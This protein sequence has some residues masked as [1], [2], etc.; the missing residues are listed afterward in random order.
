LR[1]QGDNND[2][3]DIDN[4]SGNNADHNANIDNTSGIGNSDADTAANTD[5]NDR[6][7]DRLLQSFAG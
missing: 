2:D 4:T 3:T 7:A 6:P 1:R 5:G